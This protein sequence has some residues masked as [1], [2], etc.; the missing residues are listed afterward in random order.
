MK[1][2][3][4]P[5]T[6]ELDEYTIQHEPVDSFVLMERASLAFFNKMLP[7]LEGDCRIC[8]FAGTGNN[9]GDALV[10]ARLLLIAGQSVR[11]FLVNPQNRLSPDCK[12]AKEK[13]L[14]AFP[15]ALMEIDE[16]EKIIFSS[17][18]Y[19]V[20][21][22][23]GSGLN[24][25][26]EGV[27]AEVV[28]IIN[29]SGAT[30]F[31]IDI[32]SGLFGEDNR[33]NNPN[34]IV[35]A[36]Y[37]FSFQFPK[38]A[39]FFS[40]NEPF[41]GE[42]SVLDIGL[43]PQALQ[44][45]PSTYFFTEE[46]DV[47]S[48]LRPRTKFSHKGTYGHALLIAGSCGKMGA[49]VLAAKACLRGGCGLLSSYI[50]SKGYDIMQISVPEAMIECNLHEMVLFDIDLI[51]NDKNRYTAVGIGPGI[52]TDSKVKHIL[53]DLLK[54]CKIPI[55]MDADALNIISESFEMLSRIPKGT[56]LTPHPKEFD[57]LAGYSSSGYERLQKQLKF[58][59]KHKVTVVLK[60]ANTSVAFPDGR[61][62]FNSTGNPGMATAG[63]GDVLTGIILSLLAQKYTPEEAALL[64]VYVHGLAGDFAA[65]EFSQQGMIA[66][67]IIQSL[68]KAFLQLNVKND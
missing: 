10:V 13:L 15:Y 21:G 41:I 42:F 67:D 62:F 50:P 44:D 6:K 53:S 39:F 34:A 49:A 27:F 20:D 64:G 7:Y 43:H 30:V 35:R 54:K 66:G 12:K 68:G 28:S 11:T 16:A 22:L 40:E 51:L 33:N 55:I 57:R 56:I 19:V 36:D 32:P 25:P 61:C 37:T 23:F 5:Q 14:A 52:G 2:F 47:R 45:F 46:K 38:L 65:G 48:I 24:R 26:L 31:S 8:I 59:Q 9:G 17:A 63:S 18:D 58:A 1:L 4:T 29:H 60:G 3:K